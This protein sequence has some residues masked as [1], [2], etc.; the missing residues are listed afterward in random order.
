MSESYTWARRAGRANYEATAAQQR[1]REQE[2]LRELVQKTTEYKLAAHASHVSGHGSRNRAK[3]G[4][5]SAHRNLISIT[6]TEPTHR[7][8]AQAAASRS[9]AYK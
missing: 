5:W 8:T 6:S 2:A 7:V 3:N 4:R 1:E 9:V